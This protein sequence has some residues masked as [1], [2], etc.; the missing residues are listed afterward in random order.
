M[1]LDKT[2]NIKREERIDPDAN[3]LTSFGRE[4]DFTAELIKGV[5]EKKENVELVSNRSTSNSSL[6][7]NLEKPDGKAT[8]RKKRNTRKRIGI[9]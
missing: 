2:E 1:R 5:C 7:K 6:P 9:R 3:P 8:V 4:N